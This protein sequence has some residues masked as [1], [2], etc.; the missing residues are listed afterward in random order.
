MAGDALLDGGDAIGEGVG[1][2]K[3]AI[4]IKRAA[5]Y[6]RMHGPHGHALAENSRRGVCVNRV[7]PSS[8]MAI[9]SPS[10]R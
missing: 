7:W 6:D 5:F 10:M 8:V 2:T 4:P 9:V 3:L 1:G